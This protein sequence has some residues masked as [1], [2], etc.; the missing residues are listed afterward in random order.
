MS[1]RPVMVLGATSSIARAIAEELAR[2]GH[3]LYLAGRDLPE[4]WKVASDIQIKHGVEV[5]VGVFDADDPSLHAAFI[6][7]AI[8]R[9][10]GLGG[11]VVAFGQLG[12]QAE[13]E[14]NPQLAQATIERDPPRPVAAPLVQ[15]RQVQQEP[16]VGL[17][18]RL[19]PPGGPVL[20]A[21]LRQ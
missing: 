4:L 16:E 9:T 20:V 10:K 13:T 12:D 11:A 14:K 19:A 5:N 2:E 18:Q 7:N 17:A 6:E 3:S 1:D 15:A 8:S 21:V